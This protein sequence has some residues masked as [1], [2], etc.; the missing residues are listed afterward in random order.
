MCAIFID[1]KS[2]YNTINRKVLWE[3][4]KRKNIFST[5]ELVFLKLIH[6]NI[7]FVAKNKKFY[8]KNGV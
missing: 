8:Y 4:L 1:L 3:I 7:Y 2:A 6:E 5:D